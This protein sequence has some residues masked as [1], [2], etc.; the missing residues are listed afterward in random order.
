MKDG[1]NIDQVKGTLI[2][3]AIRFGP[4]LLA[5]I[6]IMTAGVFIAGW[7]GKALL[8]GLHRFE[9]EPPMRMLFTRIARILVVLTFAILALQNLGVELLPLIAGLGVAGAGIAL[10]MQGV[11]SNVVAGLT[12]IFT[13]PYRV[14]EYIAVAGVEGQVHTI[15]LF[16]TTL[17]H[18][19][20]SRVVV[21]NRK[22]VG[23]I[24]QNF[25]K[26]RQAQVTVGIAYDSDLR[27][28]LK[29]IGELVKS[30]SRVLADP[31]PVIQALTLAD[32]AIEISLKPW[33]A[34]TDYIAVVGELNLS[35]VEELRRQ[36]VG[37]PY[38]QREVRMLA[39]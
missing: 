8:K 2:D 30:N 29:I 22:V 16:S 35:L 9:L 21:P 3:L 13:K 10:A 20:H 26:I 24:L 14:G 39:A 15:S 37:I 31:A 6:L 17:L 36:G 25:G 34:V 11:L 27:A 1:I 38:P 23:E 28:A 19:D 12:I 33:V 5:A 18:P 32:S 7:V 4:K